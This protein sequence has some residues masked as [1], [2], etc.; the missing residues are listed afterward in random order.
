ML[1]RMYSAKRTKRITS[2]HVVG[3]QLG[4]FRKEAGLTQG[5][6]AVLS[7]AHRPVLTVTPDAW[8]AFLADRAQR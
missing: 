2:W 3:A 6:L 5:G 7:E 4:V 1:V 8:G